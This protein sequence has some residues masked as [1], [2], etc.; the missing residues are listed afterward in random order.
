MTVECPYTLHGTPLPPKI[1]TSHGGSRPHLIIIPWAHQSPRSK[2][3][4]DRFSRFC[5][6]DL[7]DSDRPTDHGTRF[8]TIGRIYIRSTAMRP[9]NSKAV[10][11]IGL[12]PMLPPGESLWVYA[13][14]RR[15]CLANYGQTW[16]HPQNRATVT[17]N[18]YRKFPEVWTCVFWDTR[19]DR[20]TY[21]HTDTLVAIL[22]TPIEGK[23][24]GV[25]IV[26]FR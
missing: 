19:A 1:G 6:A 8:V 21:R 24:I 26:A 20:Q 16:R 9:N 13:Y 15:L 12:R 10:I 5:R 14:W 2:R 22:R 17:I 3:N 25:T 18:M 7:C 23:V 11:D 4:L